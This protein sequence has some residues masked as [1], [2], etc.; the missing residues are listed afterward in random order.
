MK[1]IIFIV[2]LNYT[3]FVIKL[4]ASFFFNGKING[5]VSLIKR[6]GGGGGTLDFGGG[7]RGEKITSYVTCAMAMLGS[8]SNEESEKI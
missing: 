7:E 5:I 1:P 3:I 4:I 6:E 8:F 2:M